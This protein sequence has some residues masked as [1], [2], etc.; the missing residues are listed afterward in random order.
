[1]KP[2]AIAFGL[3]FLGAAA[4]QWNDPDPAPWIALYLAAAALCIAGVFRGVPSGL[5]LGL[6]ALSALWAASLLPAIV[7]E[8][9]HTGT[10]IEREF[11]GLVLVVIAMALPTRPGA[12]LETDPAA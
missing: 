12:A 3:V 8:A 1:M 10:E 2:L 7:R 5:R 6:G 4:L 11:G 9:A